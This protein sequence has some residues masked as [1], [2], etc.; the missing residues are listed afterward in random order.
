MCICVPNTRPEFSPQYLEEIR[1]ALFLGRES[2][3]GFVCLCVLSPC[4]F[5]EVDSLGLQRLGFNLHNSPKICRCQPLERK[6]ALVA[7]G[8]LFRHFVRA[9]ALWLQTSP[10]WIQFRSVPASFPLLAVSEL[11]RF[12][13]VLPPHDLS[14]PARMVAGTSSSVA[15]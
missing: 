9:W 15:G 13:L 6:P 10:T 1:F 12:H 11:G 7:C 14:S 4:R 3:L 2:R 8:L 5:P